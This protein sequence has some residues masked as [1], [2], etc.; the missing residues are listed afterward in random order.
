MVPPETK[1]E[2]IVRGGEGGEGQYESDF[3]AFAWVMPGARLFKGCE[4][5]QATRFQR[6][7]TA[8]AAS[9]GHFERECT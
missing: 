3:G 9:C 6:A 5:K 8:I 1:P 4:G 7:A 2:D